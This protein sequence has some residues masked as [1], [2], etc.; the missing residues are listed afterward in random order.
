MIKSI[1]INLSLY[2]FILV[3]YIALI[4]CY[5][6]VTKKK[7]E[8]KLKP[9]IIV[10]LISLLSYVNTFNINII[11]KNIITIVTEFAMLSLI[12]KDK[13]LKTLIITVMFWL[14]MIVIDFGI[15]M[16]IVKY[17]TNDYLLFIKTLK[18]EMVIVGYL[19]VMTLCILN[20]IPVIS[21]FLN[22]IADLIASIKYFSIF[23]IIAVIFFLAVTTINT[24]FV[25]L[26]GSTLILLTIILMFITLAFL[27]IKVI[28][29]YEDLYNTN[30]SLVLTNQKYAN[31]ISEYKMFKHNHRSGLVAIKN[32]GN[33]KVKELVDIQLVQMDSDITI[34]E[35]A[36]SLPES[37]KGIVWQQLS[38]VDL[39]KI[40]I[41]CINNL[42]KDN[43]SSYSMKKYNDLC[44]ALDICLNNALEAALTTKNP[45]VMIEFSDNNDGV[46]IK[47]Y[48]TFN[49]EL[50][51]E[52][53]GTKEYSTKNRD[54]GYGVYSLRKLKSLNVKNR[55][56]N[57]LF[58]TVIII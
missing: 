46:E 2:I 44:I 22:R 19:I 7:I 5:K 57:D 33:K 50:D 49:C 47:I 16:Y 51:L 58:E 14:I 20:T 37:I 30:K 52:Q 43:I 1:S 9:F 45:E 35:G 24:I 21:R 29:K 10:I 42:A 15:S 56:Y 32:V 11:L 18:L 28:I 12:F 55:I 39:S 4:Y 34:I 25:K 41:K 8:F 54:S 6:R 38:L 3:S 40:N 31:S 23:L 13:I 26:G 48:N 17:I 53:F 36:E 27:L